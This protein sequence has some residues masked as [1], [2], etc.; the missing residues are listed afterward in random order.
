[1]ILPCWGLFHWIYL[2]NSSWTAL[3]V[4]ETHYYFSYLKFS[5]FP[6]PLV[7]L[8]IVYSVNILLLRTVFWCYF[9]QSLGKTTWVQKPQFLL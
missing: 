2:L 3:H 4:F 6:E 5:N 9:I 1:M 7:Y 8:E